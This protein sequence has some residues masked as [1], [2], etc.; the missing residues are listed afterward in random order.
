MYTITLTLSSALSAGNAHYAAET[1]ERKTGGNRET[2]DT[3]EI[4]SVDTVYTVHSPPADRE[5]VILAPAAWC[6]LGLLLILS[7]KEVWTERTPDSRP[8]DLTTTHTCNA[9]L[10]VP[11]R[12]SKGAAWRQYQK[13]TGCTDR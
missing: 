5:S 6:S 12:D 13:N 7:V 9:V 1:S 8:L 2:P 11:A 10:S 3:R 4:Y